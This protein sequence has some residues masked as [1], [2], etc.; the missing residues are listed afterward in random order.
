MGLC[1]YQHG[2]CGLVDEKEA[3]QA[4]AGAPVMSAV[5]GRGT[6]EAP[7]DDIQ[8]EWGQKDRL[9]F[10]REERERAHRRNG[11]EK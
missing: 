10:F 3:P 4:T 2:A 11:G 6:Q 7:G 9:W 1:P 5:T 8:A